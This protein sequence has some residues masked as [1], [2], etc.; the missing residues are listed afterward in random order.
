MI[1]HHLFIYSYGNSIK[2]IEY[3]LIE[4]LMDNEHLTQPFNILIDNFKL[5]IDLIKIDKYNSVLFGCLKII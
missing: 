5:I 4:R 3:I 2:N 1:N